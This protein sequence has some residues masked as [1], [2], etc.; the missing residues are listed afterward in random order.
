VLDPFGEAVPED[1]RTK[2]LAIKEEI[3]SGNKD[4]WAGPVIKQDGTEV[5]APGS[6]LGMEAVETMDFLVKGVIGSTS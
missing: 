2:V 1:V 6:A 3:L 5:V 4:I